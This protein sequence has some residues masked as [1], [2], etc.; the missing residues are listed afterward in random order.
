MKL[1][2]KFTISFIVLVLIV[3]ALSLIIIDRSTNHE[4]MKFVVEKRAEQTNDR[5]NPNPGQKALNKLLFAPDSPEARFINATERSLLMVSILGIVLAVIAGYFTTKFLLKRIYQLQSAMH[6][7]RENG[8]MFK[9][10]HN[11]TDEIDDLA[12]D[13]NHLIERL[14]EQEKIRKE[15]FID[16]S[17]ELKTP[18]TSVKGYLEGLVDGVYD[19]KKEIFQKALSETDR[20]IRLIK[21]L[22]VLSKMEA[23]E[24]ILHKSEVRLEKIINEIVENLSKKTEDRG[25]AIKLEGQAKA[26]IDKHKF[27]QVI[28]NL[29]DNAISHGDKDSEIA[30][31][32]R[33]EKDKAIMEI[34]NKA[35]TLEP[36]H[37]DYIFERFYR[38]DKSR[39]YD[40]S[41][42][43]LGIG[44]SIVKRII[45]AH[46]GTIRASLKDGTFSMTVSMPR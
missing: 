40:E 8:V 4:F 30:V 31:K 24:I 20:M 15:F 28:V 35:S 39:K 27:R 44:L 22:T 2:P 16:M 5:A 33:L 7:Y 43:H 41:E 26:H 36:E 10:P 1:Q 21:E 29:L 46:G 38:T 25:M 34:A 42:S 23:G 32:L 45:E 14:G 37:I 13:Y 9:V 3:V 19:P 18:I 11:N 12:N 6:D 17:H